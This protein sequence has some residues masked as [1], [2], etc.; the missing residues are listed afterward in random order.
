MDQI[1][2]QIKEDEQINKKTRSIEQQIEQMS[3]IPQMHK[4]K[5]EETSEQ[6]VTIEACDPKKAL[7]YL[8]ALKKDISETTENQGEIDYLQEINNK[9][10]EIEE[11][12]MK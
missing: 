2:N 9:I 11:K 1:I 6:E 10:K 3:N 5:V 12:R 8:A 7:E 4:Q